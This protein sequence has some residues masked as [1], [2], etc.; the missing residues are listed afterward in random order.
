MWICPRCGAM[1]YSAG[2]CECCNY[3]DAIIKSYY[4]TGTGD[5]LPAST[6]WIV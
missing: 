1:N 6:I 3:G 5:P 2:P 4:S